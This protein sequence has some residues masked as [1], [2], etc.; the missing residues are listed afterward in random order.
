M[1]TW[2]DN[3]LLTYDEW[4]LARLKT[5]GASELGVIVYGNQ[6][7][8]NLELFYEKIG[9][10]K[11]RIENIRMFLGKETEATSRKMH[12]YYEGTEQSIVD[13]IRADRKIKETVNLNSTAFNSDFPY[14]SA[15]PDS[16]I[17]PFGIYAGRGKGTLE[18]KNTTSWYLNSFDTGLP[19]DNVMQIVGQMMVCDYDYGEL[20][21]FIDNSK[22]QCH[23]VERKDA[24]NIEE[25]VYNSTTDFWERV[26]E[27]RPLYNQLY[28]AQRNYNSRLVGE[29]QNAI[30]ALEPP[31]QNTDGYLN[32]LSQKYKDKL[33]GAGVLAGNN[34]QLEVAKK[35]KELS[36]QIDKITEQKIK[37]EIELKHI[38]GDNSSI[39]FGGAGKVSWAENKAGKRIFLNK[40]NV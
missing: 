27:A 15:T 6:W 38:I 39:N 31:P 28:E 14:L 4:L 1:V 29:L 22:F 5:I 10:P 2:Q 35:H 17:Q 32:F 24:S 11:Y 23:A 20:F 40:V 7:S 18:I 30:A 26:L 12:K 9:A 13:N 8:S 21:Y 33:A 34:V 25:L 16:E 36:N 19:T 37:Y 3:S